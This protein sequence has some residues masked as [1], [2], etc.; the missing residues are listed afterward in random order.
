MNNYDP[1][2]EYDTLIRIFRFIR[3]YSTATYSLPRVCR[4]LMYDLRDAGYSADITDCNHRDY[5]ILTVNDHQYRIIKYPDW[6]RYDVTM[7][8]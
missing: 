7:V 4:E 5:R 3:E 6:S 1:S 2:N 8:A